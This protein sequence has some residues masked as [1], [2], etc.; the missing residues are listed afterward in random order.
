ML[1]SG[2][3]VHN[4]LP[5]SVTEVWVLIV[6]QSA[7]GASLRT[8]KQ[9]AFVEENV[10]IWYFP[11]WWTQRHYGHKLGVV[12]LLCLVFS[13]TKYCEVKSESGM[14][15]TIG[16]QLT[17]PLTQLRKNSMSSRSRI[18]Q[19]WSYMLHLDH[20]KAIECSAA[21]KIPCDCSPHTLRVN[22]VPCLCSSDLLLQV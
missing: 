11:G 2:G 6:P 4:L 5:W 7:A 13:I 22:I 8:R 19:G 1:P 14:S 21:L 20:S 10:D 16:F 18:D 17:L 15:E 9:M 12:I 3:A